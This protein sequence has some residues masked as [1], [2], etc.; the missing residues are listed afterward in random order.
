M[1]GDMLEKMQQQQKE[2]Q[3]ALKQITIKGN[4]PDGSVKVTANAA[5]EITDI[6]IDDSLLSAEEKEK[7]QDM[8]I[9]ALN[10]TILKAAAEEKKASEQMLKNVLPGGL[11]MFGGLGNLF[12]K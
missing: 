5:R 11:D 6:E 12:G 2:L 3:G 9:L 4:S 8:L 10:D 7:L 1:F